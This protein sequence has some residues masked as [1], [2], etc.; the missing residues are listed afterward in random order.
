M[1]TTGL[2]KWV[3]MSKE[4][5]TKKRKMGQWGLAK[6][7]I[8]PLLTFMRLYKRQLITEQCLV[9]EFTWHD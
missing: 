6:G 5:N 1:R 9:I 7:Q 2:Q 8:L 4:I 3:E